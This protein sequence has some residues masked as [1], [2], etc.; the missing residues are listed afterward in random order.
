MFLFQYQLDSDSMVSDVSYTSSSIPSHMIPHYHKLP[1]PT[2]TT[3]S[4]TSS[5][6]YRSP[7][8]FNHEYDLE[9]SMV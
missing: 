5:T 6:T 8:P 4:T 1:R 3:S 7:T 9:E 2:T